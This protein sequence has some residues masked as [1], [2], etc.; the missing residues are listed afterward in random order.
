[1]E[2]EF[3]NGENYYYKE[4]YERHDLL[5]ESYVDYYLRKYNGSNCEY[6]N[7]DDFFDRGELAA[8]LNADSRFPQ[9]N[10]QMNISYKL[11]LQLSYTVIEVAIAIETHDR[12][13]ND[14]I[15]NLIYGRYC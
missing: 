10:M 14:Y 6:V 8:K 9:V 1:M 2:R 4:D 15:K 13:R 3:V 11:E 5:V 7:I 12:I